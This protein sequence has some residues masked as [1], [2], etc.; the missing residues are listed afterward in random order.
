MSESLR[1]IARSQHGHNAVTTRSLRGHYAVTTRSLHGHYAVTTR[2]LRGHYAVTTR[3]LRGHHAVTTRSLR[4]H[5]T[6]PLRFHNQ[7]DPSTFP[8]ASSF[9]GSRSLTATPAKPSKQ[10]L[11]TENTWQRLGLIS[12]SRST[13]TRE[14]ASAIKLKPSNRLDGKI[15]RVYAVFRRIV[16]LY[17]TVELLRGL[18]THSRLHA[19]RRAHDAFLRSRRGHDGTVTMRWRRSHSAFVATTRSREAAA[20][21]S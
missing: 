11:L 14:P 12:S 5:Y 15:R 9:K 21:R 16:E 20:T 7:R 8:S 4:S 10:K 19:A 18:D 13:K 1:G 17:L 2:S 3:S 6:Q